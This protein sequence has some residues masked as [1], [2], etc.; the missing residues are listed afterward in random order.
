MSASDG[1]WKP[2]VGEDAVYD[3]A[4]RGR[5]VGINAGM[6][7][8]AVNGRRVAVSEHS[9][10]LHPPDWRPPARPKPAPKVRKVSP[11]PAAPQRRVSSR[12]ALPSSKIISGVPVAI[13]ADLR[14]AGFHVGRVAAGFVVHVDEAHHRPILVL[15]R[16]RAT[17]PLEPMAPNESSPSIHRW[18]SDLQDPYHVLRSAFR[19][20]RTASTPADR[21]CVLREAHRTSVRLMAQLRRRSP[22]QWTSRFSRMPGSGAAVPG[23]YRPRPA[24][25]P[26]AG[27]GRF[28]SSASGWARRPVPETE[29]PW[30]LWRHRSSSAAAR[31]MVSGNRQ[32]IG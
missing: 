21:I 12:A 27:R 4:G 29:A 3:R 23:R 19:E 15:A 22:T 25:R 14:A 2:E 24:A 6:V 32:S 16:A 13:V 1:V 20:W 9:P 5:V 17:G 26:S 7:H 10:H 18:P 11:T 31:E 28:A 30:V 8:L